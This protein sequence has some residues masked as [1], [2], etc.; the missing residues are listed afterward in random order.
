MTRTTLYDAS[1]FFVDAFWTAKVGGGANQLTPQQRKQLEQSQLAEFN[2]RYGTLRKMNSAE[3][4]VCR[5]GEDKIVAC[6]GVE[7]DNIPKDCLTGPSKTKAP[8]MSNLAVSRQF[9]RRGLAEE[10]VNAVERLVRDEWNHDECY[11]YVEER[12]RGAV[13]LYQKLGYRKVWKDPY[14][15]TLLPTSDGSLCNTRTT[16][17]CMRKQ[18]AGSN[19]FWNSLFS[20]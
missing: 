3:L 10:M 15:E 16:I 4:L 20:R 9:R 11:L 1:D 6:A 5:N 17:V 7:I 14:A 2:K 19:S 12:N 13:K 18:L 8:L